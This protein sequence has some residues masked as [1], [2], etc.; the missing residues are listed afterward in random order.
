MS[1]DDMKKETG[2]YMGKELVKEG[3][4]WKKYKYK[5]QVGDKT[6]NVGAFTP[7]T[8]KDGSAKKGVNAEELKEGEMYSFMYTEYQSDAMEYA[9]KTMQVVFESQKTEEQANVLR[10]EDPK[11]HE[12][13]VGA[14]V[15]ITKDDFDDLTKKYFDSVDKDKQ[16]VNHYIGTILRTFNRDAHEPLVKKYEELEPKN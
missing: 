2:K 13:T 3:D 4:T 6:W 1:N 7:W 15:N 14:R 8:K 9:S 5:F 11:P 10:E 12:V 16:S